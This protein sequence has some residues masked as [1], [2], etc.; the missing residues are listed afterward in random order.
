MG[1]DRKIFIVL[2][3]ASVLFFGL[4]YYFRP[5]NP[6]AFV[7]KIRI[8]A[9]PQFDRLNEEIRSGNY[10]LFKIDS[11]I[12]VSD[13]ENA[14]RVIN[15]SNLPAGSK[16]D[17]HGQIAARQGKYK[18]SLELFTRAIGNDVYSKSYIHRA[19]LYIKMGIMDSAITDYHRMASINSDYCRPLA[20]AYELTGK[21]I[22]L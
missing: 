18:E 5:I 8:D 21:K 12:A 1:N 19:A 7:E 14:I 20:E 2:L 9:A 4:E 17:Y 13:Y 16:L 11:L 3:I 15:S 10:L 22:V 6:A